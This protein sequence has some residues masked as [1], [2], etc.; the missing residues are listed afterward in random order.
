MEFPERRLMAKTIQTKF[1]VCPYCGLELR[2]IHSMV[3]ENTR[4]TVFFCANDK[5]R[6]VL[7]CQII[8][9]EDFAARSK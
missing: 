1:P 9:K 8:S 6:S 2:D 7:G 4:T 5:C 3:D